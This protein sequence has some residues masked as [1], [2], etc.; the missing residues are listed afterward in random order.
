MPTQIK[1]ICQHCKK[2]Y[3]KPLK[4]YNQNI[5]KEIG[6]FCS[7]KCASDARKTKT[8]CI[9]INCGTP[10]LKK[11]S[12]IGTHNFCSKSCSAIYNNQ[13]KTWGS[14][15]SKLEVFLE[16][17]LKSKYGEDFALYNNREIINS[18]L[19]IYVPSLKL[20]F[21]LNGIFHYE[22][23]Y[24]DKKLA[25]IQ[26]NDDRKFQAC[27]EKKIEFCIIDTSSQKYFKEETS[28]KYL[29]IIVKIIDK[30]LASARESNP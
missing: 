17:K 13:H 7:K 20:A 8:T 25:T 11:P 4:D 19:D 6:F 2:S 5:K 28:L 15:R 21:E 10:V 24:G 3:S 30:K 1:V 14:K 26:N 27:I 22:P 23:I 12:H 16:G 18:E 9:C 29:D